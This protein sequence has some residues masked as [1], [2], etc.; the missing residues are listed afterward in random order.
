MNDLLIGALSALLATNPPAAASN[1]VHKKTGV[2]IPVANASD[3]V[4]REFQKVMAADDAA[5]AEIEQ[6]LAEQE[7]KRA[8]GDPT[9]AITLRPRVR[10][11]LEPVRQ[12][13][14][15]FIARHPKHAGARLAFGSFLNDQGEEDAA[16]DQWEKARELAPKNAATWNNLANW[17][18][19]N[20][21]VTKAFEY[22]A[23]AIE[24]DPAEPVYYQNLAT[25]V[26]LFRRDATNFYQITERDVFAKALSLY[27]KALELDPE[28]FELATD[29]AQSYYGIR[30]QSSGDP[31]VDRQAADKLTDEALAAWRTALKIARDEEERQGVHVHLARVQINAGRFDAAR[32]SLALVT[33]ETHAAVKQVLLKKLAREEAKTKETNAPPAKP[34]E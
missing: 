31:A 26:Y 27:R 18:G 12:A 9:A 16:R 4:A 34:V 32:A 11:R 5:Q 1:L 7:R 17:Y 2:A 14:E 30:A 25:T 15:E 23:R 22:Y 13:Y 6:W 19:H 33:N 24:L 20:S 10:Q 28:N 29:Y 8:A 21:P 3:P